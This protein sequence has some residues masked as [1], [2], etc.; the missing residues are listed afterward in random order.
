MQYADHGQ[1]LTAGGGL[2]SMRSGAGSHSTKVLPSPTVEYAA[3]C[4]PCD[5]TI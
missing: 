2:P 5:S 1:G 3:T 4:P